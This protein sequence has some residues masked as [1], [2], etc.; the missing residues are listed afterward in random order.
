MSEPVAEVIAKLDV[1][2]REL[3]ELV[4]R[5]RLIRYDLFDTLDTDTDDGVE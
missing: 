4:Q 3:L 5:V 1:I 2:E